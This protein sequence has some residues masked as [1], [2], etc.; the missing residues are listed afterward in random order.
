MKQKIGTVTIHYNN[1]GKLLGTQFES[2]MKVELP[3]QIVEQINASPIL[4]EMQENADKTIGA[5]F[6]KLTDIELNKKITSEV[7]GCTRFKNNAI[8]KCI[9]TYFYE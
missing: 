2:S 6:S 5:W 8:K 4:S 1:E 3:T 7:G 9:L